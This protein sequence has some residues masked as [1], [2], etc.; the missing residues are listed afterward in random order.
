MKVKKLLLWMGLC[1]L[2]LGRPVQASAQQVIAFGMESLP[3]FTYLDERKRPAGPG[4]DIVKEVCSALQR[5]CSVALYPV[6]RLISKI[7]NGEIQG[8][9]TL[10]KNA[11]REKSFYFSRP[12]TK[13]EYGFFIFENSVVEIGSL[14]DLEGY[15]VIT[16]FGSNML[17]T[18]QGVRKKMQVDFEISTEITLEKAFKKLSH[19]RYQKEKIAIFANRD[20]GLNISR[21]EKLTNLRYTATQ[22]ELHYY[23]GFPKTK[24][25]EPFVQAYNREMEKMYADGRLQR[26]LDNYSMLM[27][28]RSVFLN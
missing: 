7:R 16:L 19:G 26:I 20:V 23:M 25:I 18:L 1:A 28:E 3:P 13:T 8:L 5:E 22:K 15:T 12:Y 21:K 4:M 11:E 9:V 6:K 24:A 17:A 10:G 27:P 2:V 14:Q